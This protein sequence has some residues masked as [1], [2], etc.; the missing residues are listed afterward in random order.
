MILGH[1]E[2]RLLALAAPA[3][4]PARAA[5]CARRCTT[6]CPAG[7]ARC[8]WCRCPSRP[9][10]DPAARATSRPPRSPG[11]AAAAARRTA[12]GRPPACR[13]LRTRPRPGRPGRAR[14]GRA[15]GQPRRRAPRAPSGRAP[16]GPAAGR[17]RSTSWSATTCSPPVRPRP[18]RSARCGRSGCRRWR[19]P[20]WPR[21]G[22]ARRRGR[23]GVTTARPG[24]GEGSAI[25]GQGLASDHGVRPGPWLRRPGAPVVRDVRVGKPMPVAGETAHVRRL[26]AARHAGGRRS[27]CGLVVS[28]A[29]Q[30]RQTRGPAGE[31]Q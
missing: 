1:K 3:R 12:L 6:W 28:P 4:G 22:V 5:P 18:R 27:R 23:T 19:W 16:A 13:L 21:P 29:L 25:T 31:G 8:C 15:R 30:P 10:S 7:P 17:R 24:P 26:P 9:S 14:R 20:R 2:H 11:A